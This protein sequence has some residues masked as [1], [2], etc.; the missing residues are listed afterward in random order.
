MR[1]AVGA[2]A[3]PLFAAMTAV[4]QLCSNMEELA[5][6]RAVIN[7]GGRECRRKRFVM[8]VNQTSMRRRCKVRRQYCAAEELGWQELGRF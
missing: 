2:T 1:I 6:M 8:F 4:Q 7:R 5:I 3:Y